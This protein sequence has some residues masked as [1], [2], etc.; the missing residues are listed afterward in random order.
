MK[1][2]LRK[3][4]KTKSNV[5][6]V[7][8]AGGRGTRFWPL[9]RPHR[10]KQLLK[11]LSSKSLIR[12]TVDRVLPLND[13]QNTLVVTVADHVRLVRKELP[14]DIESFKNSPLGCGLYALLFGTGATKVKLGFRVFN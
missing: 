9:S 11:I 7:I 4:P 5:Y 10:P 13:H 2:T 6:A 12:E 1:A 14:K 8:M 3:S